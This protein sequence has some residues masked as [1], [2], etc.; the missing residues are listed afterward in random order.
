MAGKFT[1]EQSANYLA[2]I[3]TSVIEA[4]NTNIPLPVVVASKRGNTKVFTVSVEG[5]NG[6]WTL[7]IFNG[8]HSSHVRSFV[9]TKIIEDFKYAISFPKSDT[10]QIG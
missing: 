4:T 1:K 5:Q 6:W 7:D 9:K 3:M 8:V 10:I 2:G